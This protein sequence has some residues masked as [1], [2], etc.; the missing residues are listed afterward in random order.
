MDI[1]KRIKADRR[2]FPHLILGLATGIIKL[3]AEHN[4]THWV[5]S[6]HPATNRLL[7]FYGLQLEAIGPSSE[8]HGLRKP[9]YANL[10]DVLSRMYLNHRQIWELVTDDGK[11][12]PKSLE[13]RRKSRIPMHGISASY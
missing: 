7:G 12:W 4:I 11:F 13:R 5:S 10:S 3:C 9:Y 6:M 1:E 2:V 8:Y